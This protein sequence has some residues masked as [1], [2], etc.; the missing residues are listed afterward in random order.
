MALDDPKNIGMDG[1][2][3]TGSASSTIR[4]FHNNLK[5]TADTSTDPIAITQAGAFWA[6]RPKGA[7][8]LYLRAAWTATETLGGS[9]EVTVWGVDAVD[10]D[11]SPIS[12]ANTQRL[13]AST[14]LSPT[15]IG[16]DTLDYGDWSSAIDCKGMAAVIVQVSVAGTTATAAVVQ[17]QWLN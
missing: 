11:G 12:T 7:T 1:Q 14:A 17:G 3:L 6:R 5:V 9:P 13:L 16:T 4:Q 15:K 10:A 8:N 2:V